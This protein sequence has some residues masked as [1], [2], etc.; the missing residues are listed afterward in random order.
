VILH[1]FGISLNA[2]SPINCNEL[3]SSRCSSLTQF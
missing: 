1:V 2:K 3:G